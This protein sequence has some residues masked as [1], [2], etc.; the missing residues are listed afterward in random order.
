MLDAAVRALHNAWDQKSSSSPSDVS[1]LSEVQRI[2]GSMSFAQ[3]S[4]TSAGSGPRGGP[5]ITSSK[6]NFSANSKRSDISSRTS[7][8]VPASTTFFT[9]ASGV[10]PA[11]ADNPSFF[12]NT[13]TSFSLSSGVMPRFCRKLSK[14]HQGTFATRAS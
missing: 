14:L 10:I 9:S 6:L 13:E 1:F 7:P 3:T 5:I 11:P 2:D 12:E 4:T 8:G